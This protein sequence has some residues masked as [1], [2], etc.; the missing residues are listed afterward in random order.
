MSFPPYPEY[1]D[2]GIPWLAQIPSLWQ[3]E[4]LLAVASE[5]DES[6]A[7]MVENNLLSLS[8]GRI[9]PKDIESNDGLLPESFETYQIVEPDDIVFRL[10]DLQNDKRSLR[11]A[12]VRERGIITSAYLAVRPSKIVPQY[13]HYA[14]RACDEQKVFY[15]MGGGLRQSMKYSDIKRFPLVIPSHAEQKAIAAFLDHE[16]AKIDA[17]VAEQ[18]KLITLLKEKR[19]AVIS[20]AVTKGLNPD[21][22]TKDSGVEWLG[23]VPAH[24]ECRKLSS[25]AFAIGDGL[26]GTPTYLDSS[27]YFFINGNNLSDGKI[28]ITDSTRCVSYEEYSSQAIELGPNSVLLSIN[29][30]IGN[31]ALYEG[32]TVMLGKSAAYINCRSGLNRQFLAYFIMSNSCRDYFFQSLAGTTIHNLSLETIRCTRI[33]MPSLHEQEAIVQYLNQ[34][35]SRFDTL[36]LQSER[37]IELLRE[38]RSA[39]IS[40]AVTGKIDVRK[41][42]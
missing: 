29:G 30:T 35:T 1:K 24:W 36:I 34:E 16:T 3:V 14:L 31:V 13:L 10:T 41:A 9:V 33:V 8:Y 23:E 18:E 17:L 11:T 15:S 6:N 26:H 2:C 12:I 21:A 27:E 5:R 4:P 32:E 28:E 38:R 20:N 22:P 40:A 25:L 19:Q 7:G 39:L 42:A 37:A